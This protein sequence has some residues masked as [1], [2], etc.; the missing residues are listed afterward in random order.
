MSAKPTQEQAATLAQVFDGK[1]I[2][3]LIEAAT[4]HAA[5]L[6]RLDSRSGDGE[7]GDDA[8]RLESAIEVLR[9]VNT[10][11]PVLKGGRR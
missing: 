5:T 11:R 7:L 3:V 8:D 4:L 2:R 10:L 1:V 6:R 9:T